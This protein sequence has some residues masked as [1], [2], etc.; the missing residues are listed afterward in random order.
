M[1]VTRTRVAQYQAVVVL[2][3]GLKVSGWSVSL[4]TGGL[5]A[6]V[7]EAHDLLLILPA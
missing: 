7:Q 6:P 3:G 4:L 2:R 1:H 5:K